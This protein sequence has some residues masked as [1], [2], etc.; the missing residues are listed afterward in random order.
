MVNTNLGS[1]FW[2]GSAEH[3]LCPKPLQ[4]LVS[5]FF[6]FPRSIKF[7]RISPR[8][9]YFAFWLLWVKCLC[10]YRRRFFCVLVFPN[11]YG[12]KCSFRL[13][14]HKQCSQL[15]AGLRVVF[16]RHPIVQS[17]P[18]CHCFKRS[19]HVHSLKKCLQ[20]FMPKFFT[21]RHSEAPYPLFCPGPGSS[22]TPLTTRS[23]MASKIMPPE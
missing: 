17:A 10:G 7:L 19:S 3:A 5:C 18:S 6:P 1:A 22:A 9:N 14:A 15:F 4:D 2:C 20:P 12:L 13:L 21:T 16:C 8:W 11:N 23:T